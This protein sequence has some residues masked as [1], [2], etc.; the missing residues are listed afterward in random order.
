M[1]ELC[2]ASHRLPAMSYRLPAIQ[3]GGALTEITTIA[4][5]HAHVSSEQFGTDVLHLPGYVDLHELQSEL[6]SWT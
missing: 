3:P 1:N 6:L 2:I 4:D 5:I